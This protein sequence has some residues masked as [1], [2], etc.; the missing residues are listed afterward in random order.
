MATM[1]PEEKKKVFPI[2]SSLWALVFLIA[3]FLGGFFLAGQSP[4]AQTASAWGAPADVDF[5]P[6]W[7]AW[8]AID[9]KFVP[10]S[11]ASTTA[12]SSDPIEERV[13]GMISGLADSLDDPYTFFLPPSDNQLFA[14]DMSGSFGGVGM[15]IEVRDGV[16]IVVSPLRDTPAER[17]GIKTGD[18]ILKINGTE[19]T[20]MDVTS[21]VKRIR[22][23]RGTEVALTLMR[24]G[25]AESREFNVE[26]DVI[27]VP[28]VTTKQLPDG[29]FLIN[30]A[31]FAA[32][33]P[34]LFRQALRSFVES[35]STKLILDLRGNPGGYL[36]AAVDMAS[37]FLPAGKVVV[38]EDYAGHRD[39]IPHRSSGYN[40]FNENLRM[41]ILVNKGSASA[42]EILADALRHY[43]IAQL[44]G[45]NT[46]G[47]G[48][49]QELVDITPGTSLKLTVAR[50]MGPDGIVIPRE[51]IAPDVKVEIGEEDAAAGRD[52]QLDEAVQFLK[53]E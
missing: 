33:S 30:V 8:K 51:G 23:P 44:V 47:K 38:T 18:R 9:E 2:S 42:S 29:I 21:A 26:R 46:F 28:I 41:V 7:R 12:T 34:D 36:E 39:N 17:A 15:E 45:T 24:D 40:V 22:G 4:A 20:G 43:G 27:N 35:K 19:T 48:S 25:W 11:V 10:A 50:W 14:D 52:P 37:W 3:G 13:W 6:V 16:L 31:S 53:G 49:V 1:F 32:N 5:S